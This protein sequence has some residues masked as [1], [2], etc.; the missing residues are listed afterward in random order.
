MY[1]YEKL[2]DAVMEALLS[3]LYFTKRMKML[4]R[5]DG[6]MLHGNLGVDISSTSELLYPNM[7]HRLGVIRARPNFY[8]ISH[9]P[10]ASFGFFDCSFYTRCIALKDDYRKE[11]MDILAYTP[12]E[13]NFSETLA[14]TSIRPARE[15]QPSKNFFSTMLRFV[16]LPLQ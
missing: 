1:N 2:R 13:F 10:N 4:T 6:F 15:N 8:M 5:R 3:E 14:K 7:K 16:E 9:N 12:M 11:R